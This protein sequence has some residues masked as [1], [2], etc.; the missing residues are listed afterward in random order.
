MKVE[1][2]EVICILDFSIQ[3]ENI[4][5]DPEILKTHTFPLHARVTYQHHNSIYTA[6]QKFSKIFYIFPMESLM[7]IINAVFIWSEIQ[8]K[9]VILWSIIA[10]S[11]IGFPF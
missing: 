7:L 1:S 10:I 9:N 4:L 6:A 5:W 11:N 3:T 2:F 8:K